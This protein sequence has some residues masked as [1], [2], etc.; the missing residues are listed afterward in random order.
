M[1]VEKRITEEINWAIDEYCCEKL[2]HAIMDEFIS[3][4]DGQPQLVVRFYSMYLKDGNLLVN[5]V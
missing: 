4:K 5:A 2:E 3:L 1:K